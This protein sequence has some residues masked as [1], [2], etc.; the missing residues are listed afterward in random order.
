MSCRTISALLIAS[1]LMGCASPVP[2]S[3][4]ATSDLAGFE[5]AGQMT[6]RRF[7]HASVLLQDGTVLITGGAA[8]ENPG[9]VST[10]LFRASTEVFDPETGTSSRR[11]NLSVP[12]IL[13]M[14]ILMPDGRVLLAGAD[15]APLEFFD[16]QTGRFT[17]EPYLPAFA[18]IWSITLL[19]NGKIL[20]YYSL[21]VAIFDPD[22][23][24]FTS[25]SG[26]VVIRAGHTATLLRDGRVLIVG[27]GNASGAVKE[28]EIYDPTS[29]KLSRTGDL[30]YDRRDH[31]AILLRDGSV[32]VIGGTTGDEGDEESVTAAERYDPATGTFLSE[33]DPGFDAIHAATLLPSGEVF[34]I[35]DSGEVILY[36]PATGAFGPTGDSIGENR[37][38]YT[39]TLL[40]DGRVLI[41][42]GLK[43]LQ[44][45]D[46]ILIYRP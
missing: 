14:G 12:R 36:D 20:T 10:S 43:D 6:E 31:R 19:P 41:T 22:T 8:T 34:I 44:A 15:Q 24:E 25:L 30:R 29:N 18:R 39:T 37:V 28:S 11:G 13:D 1:I 33:G 27:G 46:Q 38:F 32:L 2:T 9:Q 16:P 7:W 23:R 40:R 42:G 45:T 21:G 5:V 26:T 17:P 3:P 35:G 4:E